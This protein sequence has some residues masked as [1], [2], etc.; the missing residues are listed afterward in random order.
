MDDNVRKAEAAL[1]QS[2][3]KNYYKILGVGITIIIINYNL[4]IIISIVIIT[5]LL[6]Y[7][8]PF[9]YYCQFLLLL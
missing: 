8:S 2:K 9:F 3:Q 5:I 1:K 4:K 7:F 6:L